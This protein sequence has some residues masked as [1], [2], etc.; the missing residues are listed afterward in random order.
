M[1]GSLSC[2]FSNFWIFLPSDF[3]DA[4]KEWVLSARDNFLVILTYVQ[5]RSIP[6]SWSAFLIREESPNKIH[7]WFM[8]WRADFVY[9][10]SWLHSSI[11]RTRRGMFGPIPWACWSS[12]DPAVHRPSWTSSWLRSP[13][14][15]NIP[16][17]VSPRRNNQLTRNTFKTLPRWKQF[18]RVTMISSRTSNNLQGM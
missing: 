14:A 11:C 6:H 16:C 15:F 4:M 3:W 17:Q 18:Y 8:I 7:L 12:M 13:T 1:S 10:S 9:I 5:F 2:L